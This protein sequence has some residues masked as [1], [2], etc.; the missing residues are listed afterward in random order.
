ME[1][2]EFEVEEVITVKFN[3]HPSNYT[4]AEKL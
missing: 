1:N 3:P 4:E 2:F